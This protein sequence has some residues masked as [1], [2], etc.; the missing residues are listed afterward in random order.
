[1]LPFGAFAER[2]THAQPAA[3]G[4]TLFGVAIVA[5]IV[6]ARSFA[7]AREACDTAAKRRIRVRPDVAFTTSDRNNPQHRYTR[8]HLPE[9]PIFQGLQV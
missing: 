5:G 8:D 1:V 4:P 6:H 9:S 2:A 7:R 3:I